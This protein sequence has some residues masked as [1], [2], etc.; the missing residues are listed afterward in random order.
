ME[1][2]LI[3]FPLPAACK[4]KQLNQLHSPS[5]LSSH[6]PD[7]RLKDI[8]GWG[9]RYQ[10]QIPLGVVTE[11][12]GTQHKRNSVIL[13]TPQDQLTL[14]VPDS[15]SGS[16]EMCHFQLFLVLL[17]LSVNSSWGLGAPFL[18]VDSCEPPQNP[19]IFRRALRGCKGLPEQISLQNWSLRDY[20]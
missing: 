9:K 8:G 7:F 18:Q 2:Q 6:L 14:S 11:A 12:L 4:A 20:T 1:N 17:A 3:F 16:A 13:D 10:M 5:R 19:I 15:K